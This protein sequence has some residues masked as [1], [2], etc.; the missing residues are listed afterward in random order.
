MKFLGL[1]VPNSMQSSKSTDSKK[2]TTAAVANPPQQQQ[3]PQKVIIPSQLHMI[4]MTIASLRESIR[5]MNTLTQQIIGPSGST[6]R[7]EFTEQLESMAHLV[8][9]AN[10]H[11]ENFDIKVAQGE[12]Q[13]VTEMSKSDLVQLIE[14]NSSTPSTALVVGDIDRLE[15]YTD[16]F[17][18]PIARYSPNHARHIESAP[19]SLGHIGEADRKI[20]A[21]TESVS[22]SVGPAIVSA[23]A[24]TPVRIAP[25]PS[26]HA[27]VVGVVGQVHVRPQLKPITHKQHKPR[28]ADPDAE[29]LLI[30]DE[31][32][33]LIEEQVD[34]EPEYSDEE[35]LD[36]TVEV[37]KQPR[38]IPMKEH[39]WG[40]VK[41][42]AAAIAPTAATKEK[43][44]KAPVFL[45][46]T[47]GPVYKAPHGVSSVFRT[48]LIPKALFDKLVQVI[49]APKV[50]SPPT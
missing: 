9:L 23:P 44:V 19:A 6:I 22:A 42:K 32:G 8:R 26:N 3:Q 10:L 35:A 18:I 39:T 28:A 17:S 20:T 43:V 34:Q 41:A 15:D 30:Y 21:K 27:T 24:S 12:Y 47:P 4:R 36:E 11:M 49:V 5:A 45:P 31:D 2:A 33:N 16:V 40:V 29:P 37:E 1:V 14:D 50:K 48:D 7:Q 46:V 25:L 13:P 38:W